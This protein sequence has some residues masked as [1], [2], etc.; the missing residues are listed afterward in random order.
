MEGSPAKAVD[1]ATRERALRDVA[2]Q[3]GA[4]LGNLALGIVVTALV[5]RTLGDAGYGQWATL[6]ALV[7]IAS[8]FMQ[9]G[10][11]RVA[12]R[13]AASD[14]EKAADW[15][16]AL[17]MVRIALSIPVVAIGA[18]VLVFLQEDTTMLV[19]GLILLAELPL[20]VGAALQV[21]H[22]L[23]MR[24]SVPMA[25]MTLNSVM[26]GVLV[27]AI[28]LADGGL[29]AFAIALAGTTI[30]TSLVQAVAAIRLAPFRVRPSRAAMARLL[31]T[32]VSV[33]VAGMLVVAYAKIGQLL[34]FTIAGAS[35]A[36]YY[37]AAHMIL[38]RAHV[39]PVSVMTTLAPVTASAWPHRRERLMQV[40]RLATEFLAI[41][42]LGGLAVAIVAAEPI[43]TLLLGDD[44]A[45]AAS[46][47]PVLGGAF[48]LICFSY[49]TGNLMLV[50]GLTRRM[51]VVSLVALVVAVAGNLL[52]IPSYG[53]MG[54]A[55]VVLATELIV[56]V[57]GVV[58][59]SRVFPIHRMPLGRLAR[60]ALAAALTCGL[61][62][63]VQG[64]G[65]GLAAV[66]AV[67]VVAY[68]A[69]LLLLRGVALDEL[70]TLGALRR[71][72]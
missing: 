53:F 21:V 30:V 31:R 19:A 61:L 28:W 24:N 3:I 16:G 9:F 49:L 56:V 6:L 27:V 52:L 20:S 35:A 11:E 58:F 18:I 23:R 48:T 37:G 45:P 72:V 66:L 33:G 14:P 17:V 71:A 68:P 26:W 41:A 7:E 43:V 40:V 62:A 13:E 50:L 64:A 1:H 10:M 44:F 38:D 2:V 46:A 39:V 54:A 51:V 63:V 4:R 34:V 70:R 69:L 57:A 59:V 47:L 32:G 55:W 29:I 42:S 12:I 22:T 8:V 15:V 36:G 65:A 67:A 5:V 60:I 25:V